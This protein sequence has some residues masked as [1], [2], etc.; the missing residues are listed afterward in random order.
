MAKPL[1]VEF[2]PTAL[3][4]LEDIAEY[5]AEDNPAAAEEWVLKLVEAAEKVPSHPR[6]GR[7]VPEVDD[8]NI[9]EII[10]GKYRVI[11][12]LDPKRLLVLT[13]IEGHRR[14]RELAN[15]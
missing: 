13:A 14:L 3:L 10:V 4:D 6:S 15:E 11:Y 1:K 7:T 12:R 2:S 8:P 5:I 9:R